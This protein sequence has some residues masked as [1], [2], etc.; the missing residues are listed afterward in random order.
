M[1]GASTAAS[2]IGLAEVAAKVIPALYKYV[3]AVRHAPA[4]CN[5]ILVELAA[6]NGTLLAARTLIDDVNRNA[7][8]TEI[9]PAFSNLERHKEIFS[10]C[11]KTLEQILTRLA[12]ATSANGKMKWKDRVLWPLKEAELS[13][14]REELARHKIHITTAL[15]LDSWCVRLISANGR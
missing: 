2:L 12:K 7:D 5:S 10:G 9:L 3:A 6:I 14:F 13:K 11:Q 15:S 4:E 8:A 1:D